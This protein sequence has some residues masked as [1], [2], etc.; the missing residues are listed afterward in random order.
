MQSAPGI[1][2]ANAVRSRAFDCLCSHPRVLALNEFFLEPGFQLSTFHSI[3]IAPGE[4]PQLLHYDDSWVNLARPRK[5]MGSAIMVPL[6][7]SFT[8]AGGAT[9]VVP[10]SHV[11]GTSRPDETET[12]PAECP[13]G[14]AVFFI[15]TTW[16][17]GGGNRS[18]RPRES[19][20]VQYCQPYVR[21]HDERS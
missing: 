12:I 16:H 17:G 3:S 2:V 5:P 15:S 8:A 4:A 18:K 19:V 13:Q 10:A 7:D 9:R 20:T 11:R 6:D 21:F 1:C 14:G